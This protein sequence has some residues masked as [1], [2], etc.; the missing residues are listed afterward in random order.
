VTASFESEEK[1]ATSPTKKGEKMLKKMS[2]TK[3][4]EEATS[5]SL[6]SQEEPTESRP[7]YIFFRNGKKKL[8]WEGREG[9]AIHPG[10]K[11]KEIPPEKKI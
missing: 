8:A 6:H 10:W 5:F 3:R 1:K 9:G 7:G 4:R 2:T 11:R